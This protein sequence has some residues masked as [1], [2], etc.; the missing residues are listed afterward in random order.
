MRFGVSDGFAHWLPADVEALR[1]LVTRTL[2]PIE[3][4]DE[5]HKTQL[6]ESLATFFR[7]RRRLTEAASEL[8]VHK[9]TLAYRL[10]RIEELTGRDLST[11][12][13]AS[14][15]WLALK[16]LPIVRGRNQAPED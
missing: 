2:G 12:E 10:R 16:A 11:M 9:H 7:H 8:Y 1:Q 5:Q 6:V 15:L 4:Y 3:E 14:E 13:D